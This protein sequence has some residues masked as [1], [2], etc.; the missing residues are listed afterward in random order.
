MGKHIDTRKLIEAEL[1]LIIEA[2]VPPEDPCRWRFLPSL[3]R[4]DSIDNKGSNK[5]ALL[6]SLWTQK[7]N[8]AVFRVN[9]VSLGTAHP[10]VPRKTINCYLG[11]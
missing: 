5:H 7:R 1:D 11:P 8:L 9:G 6:I 4:D 10:V 3:C 2:T